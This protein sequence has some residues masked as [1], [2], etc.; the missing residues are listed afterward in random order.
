MEDIKS[1]IKKARRLGFDAGT[2]S[3]SKFKEY[4]GNVPGCDYSRDPLI[5]IYMIAGS[6]LDLSL[7]AYTDGYCEVSMDSGSKVAYYYKGYDRS[8]AEMAFVRLGKELLKTEEPVGAWVEEP[9]FSPEGPL[10]SLGSTRSME[11]KDIGGLSQ[12]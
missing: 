11:V 6:Q 8:K 9:T 2:V 12:G 4:W 10:G 5:V 1:F 7:I 3:G